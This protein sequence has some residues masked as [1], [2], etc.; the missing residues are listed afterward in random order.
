MAKNAPVISQASSGQSG[1]PSPQ[2]WRCSFLST[3]STEAELLSEV[4][5]FL[6]KPVGEELLQ[7]DI[8][9]FKL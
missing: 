4:G 8:L 2:S 6:A 3:G 9:F 5:V 7:A 1:L